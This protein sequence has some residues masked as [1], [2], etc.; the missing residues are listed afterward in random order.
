MDLHV[1]EDLQHF[2]KQI[3]FYEIASFRLNL[4]RHFALIRTFVCHLILYIMDFNVEFFSSEMCTNNVLYKGLNK[5]N[6]LPTE[7]KNCTPLQKCK[8]HLNE[9]LKN[10]QIF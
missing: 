2:L 3:F 9:F 8:I 10:D 1:S 5:F 7:L 6:R 4:P